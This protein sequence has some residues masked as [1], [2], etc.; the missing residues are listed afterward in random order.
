MDSQTLIAE[1]I[2]RFSCG[3][4]PVVLAGW[5]S[6]AVFI[7]PGSS[8]VTDKT[9]SGVMNSTRKPIWAQPWRP[10]LLAALSCQGNCAQKNRSWSQ[11]AKFF[12]QEVCQGSA[13]QEWPKKKRLFY[14]M[15]VAWI[16]L[17]KMMKFWLLDMVAN[18]CHVGD[19]SGILFKVVK[20]ASVS[21]LP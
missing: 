8:V 10:A 17:R 13:N 14:P 19:I 4:R 1:H 9:T 3:L 11:T 20:I 16:L 18:K 2:K 5:T 12:H 21:L 6:V 15:M 7:L